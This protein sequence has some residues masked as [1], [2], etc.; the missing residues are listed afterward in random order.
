MFCLTP[1]FPL[2]DRL[3]LHPTRDGHRNLLPANARERVCLKV[4]D[5]MSVFLLPSRILT[6]CDQ[7]PLSQ[8]HEQTA[9]RLA[10]LADG[11]GT[12]C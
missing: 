9:L 7:V 5:Q 1:E 6:P 12:G 11:C 10:W 3:D 2:P 8:L 4:F